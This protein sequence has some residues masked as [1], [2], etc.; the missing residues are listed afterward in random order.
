MN[1]LILTSVLQIFLSFIFAQDTI[2]KKTDSVNF[3]IIKDYKFYDK[4]YYEFRTNYKIKDG[5]YYEEYGLT[6]LNCTY[7]NGEKNGAEITYYKNLIISMISYKKGVLNGNFFY[8]KDSIDC[9]GYY[10]D[11]KRI[12]KWVYKKNGVLIAKGKFNGY[13][14]LKVIKGQ[15][16][17]IYNE[18]DTIIFDNYTKLREYTSKY[19]YFIEK[20]KT[21]LRNGKWLF[22][23]NNG[24]KQ[25]IVIYDKQGKIKRKKIYINTFKSFDL[26]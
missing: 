25:Q 7:T 11:G 26:I 22:Y 18:I 9:Y 23:D 19:D 5:L 16:A 17:L 13:M 4:I 24:Q 21:W 15:S 10:K 3:V 6:K 2:I 12:K 14:S 20:S 1:K 8:K